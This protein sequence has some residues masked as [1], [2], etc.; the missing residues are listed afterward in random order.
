MKKLRRSRSDK[1]IFGVCGGL[2][3]YLS[4]DPTIIRLIWFILA[5][6]SFGTFALA[7]LI[8]GLVIPEDDG[9]I[10]SD[11]ENGEER[12][13]NSRLV[14]GIGLVIIGIVLLGNT[15]FPWFSYT[16]R[17]VMKLWPALLIVLG[18]YVLVKK[19]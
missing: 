11:E 2:G 8:C 12:K 1:Y 18:I 10:H 16:M 7:Y 15:M 9:Y 13:D 3:E 6:T 17:Q 19:D 14:M 4:M 5:L